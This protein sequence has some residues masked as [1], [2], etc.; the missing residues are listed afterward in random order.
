MDEII[1]IFLLANVLAFFA[2]PLFLMIIAKDRRKMKEI[3]M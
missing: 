1:K 3:E 2:F